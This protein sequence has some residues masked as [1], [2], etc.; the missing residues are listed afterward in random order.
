M[1][2]LRHCHEV[3]NGAYYL[4]S[5][6]SNIVSKEYHTDRTATISNGGY[7]WWELV[8]PTEQ[9]V[10]VCIVPHRHYAVVGGAPA[11]IR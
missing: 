5:T 11:A 6:L 2:C 9:M 1:C 8:P 10:V 3:A 4:S 7:L